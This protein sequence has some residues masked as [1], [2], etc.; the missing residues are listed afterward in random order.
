M[1]AT[2]SRIGFILQD[3]RIVTAGPDSSVDTKYGKLARKTDEPIETYFDDIADAQAICNAR[4]A[5][6]SA[7]RR[8]FQQSISGEAFALG[9]SY[10]QTT[11]A[12]TVV[13][14]ERQANLPAAIVEIGI[15]FEAGKST[16]MTWG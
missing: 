8:R 11:P 10:N 1:P 5:L 2:S 6:L 3:L 15:D 9:L 7:D 4:K 13:D 12:V 14:S 16:V